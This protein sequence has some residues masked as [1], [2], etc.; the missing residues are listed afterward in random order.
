MYRLGRPV[1]VRFSVVL[2]LVLWASVPMARAEIVLAGM[3]VV[4]AD[5][6]DL[7]APGGPG[8]AAGRFRLGGFSAIEYLGHG[9]RYLV[10]ADRGPD[11]GRSDFR[12]RFHEFE[13]RIGRGTPAAV[14]ARLVQTT[15]LSGERGQ[16]FVGMC[17]AIDPQRPD[18]GLRFDPEGLRSDGERLFLS[19]E[20][21]PAVVQFDPSGRRVR[22]VPLPARF[23][24]AQSHAA[25]EEE[26]RQNQSGRIP[27]RG[28]EGLAISAD[29]SRLYAAMQGPLI[30][31]SAPGAKGRRYGRY[32]RLL[33]IAPANGH[34]RELAVPLDDVQ[35]G[36]SEILWVGPNQL[37]AL[38][39][40]GEAGP[41]ARYKRFYHLDLT[42]ATDISGQEALPPDRLPPGLV[43]VTKRPFL[44]LLAPQFGLAGD[45]LPEK[46]E[47]LALGP[48]L[49]D[50]RLSLLV[51]T[52]NDFSPQQ[53]SRV[54]VFAVDPANLPSLPQDHPGRPEPRTAGE[55]AAD[56]RGRPA[57]RLGRTRGLRAA[58]DTGDRPRVFLPQP[59]VAWILSNPRNVAR[60]GAQ[61]PEG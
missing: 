38:E 17:S 35:T 10:L 8:S 23:R 27:N 46:F 33:E 49:P 40:D 59:A 52:D 31:D 41:D 4:P 56:D 26:L 42:G 44:D 25:P 50:G 3:A 34:L 47:G 19:D 32:V 36:V 1:C 14:T 37:L 7:A 54:L 30:Q 15:V 51:V 45:E 48:R 12:C 58:A 29:G 20:Y 22:Q 5:Q 11:N 60:Q 55:P 9:D 57:D 28:L 53:P 39:R 6:E 24:I 2:A 43:P 18:G 61:A 13:I 21:G 16:P